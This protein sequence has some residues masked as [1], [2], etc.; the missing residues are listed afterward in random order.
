MNRPPSEGWESQ[1]FTYKAATK[2]DSIYAIDVPEAEEAAR[3]LFEGF[4]KVSL[5]DDLIG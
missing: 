5:L 4:K 1:T 2:W 3:L